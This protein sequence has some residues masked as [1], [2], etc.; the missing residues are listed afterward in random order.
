MARLTARSPCAGLE[1]ASVG[2]RVLSE[3]DYGAITSVAPFK[4]RERD[5]SGALKAAIGAGIPAPNRVIGKSGAR[6]VWS[7]LGQ[8]MVL[9]PPVAPEGAAVTDQ[10]DAWACL[11]LSGQGSAEVLSRLTPLDLRDRRFRRG[12]AGRSL[13]GHVPCLF[14]RLGSARYEM[15]VFRSMAGTAVHELGR[16][17]EDAAAQVTL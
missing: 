6:V 8:A 3:V 10:S 12:H 17:M 13:L 15:L 2:G 7:G 4:G 11:A 1:L 9:G 16:A 14:L 5:V